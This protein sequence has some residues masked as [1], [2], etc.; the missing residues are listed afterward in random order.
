MPEIDLHPELK[1]LCD[2][3]DSIAQAIVNG[4]TDNRNMNEMYGWNSPALNRH[5]LARFASDLS[6][7]I[8]NRAIDV[9][10]EPTVKYVTEARGN[11]E[12]IKSNT[13]PQFWGGNGGVASQAYMQTILSVRMDLEPFLGWQSIRDTNLIPAKLAKRI[14][15]YEATL[16]EITP[17]RDALIQSIKT[18]TEATEAA[19][20]LP[21]D[22]AALTAARNKIDALQTESI[23]MHG[24]INGC[25]TES[26]S[27]SQNIKSLKVEATKLVDQCEQAYRITT[28]K[29][30]AAAFDLR[31]KSL[32]NSMWIWVIG[33]IAALTTGY[34]M[35][36][37]RLKELTDLLNATDKQQGVIWPTVIVA[38]IS[39]GAPIWL[40]WIA[41]KQIGQRFRL[42]EDYGFKASVAKAYEGY[43]K[44]AARIDKAFEARLFSSA[45]TRL[46]EAPLR[47]VEVK[48]HGSPWHELIESEGFQQALKIVPA[49]REQFNRTQKRLGTKI[50]GGEVV[51]PTESNGNTSK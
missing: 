42:S 48:T 44:E 28:T 4:T 2:A 21:T 26:N 10:D 23:G 6:Q 22:L 32:S 46:E 27:E 9:L 51:N 30:L 36:S 11:I 16:D 43:R 38:L 17:K 25:L 35:G 1:K 13:L 49:L 29:G 15:S 41:T 50:T 40:A 37:H 19:E 5:A 45:L 3:L 34:I 33:L 12:R 20:S 39:L 18:I 8:R 24:K 7:T 47:L 31:A 14:R